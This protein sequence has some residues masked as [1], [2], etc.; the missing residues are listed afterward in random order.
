MTRST[1]VLALLSI[2]LAAPASGATGPDPAALEKLRAMGLPFT[3]GAFSEATLSGNLPA[4]QAYLDAGM[5]PNTF[6]ENGEFIATYSERMGS[7]T[8]PDVLQMLTKAGLDWKKV[9]PTKTTMAAIMGR[10]LSQEEEVLDIAAIGLGG[11]REQAL[12]TDMANGADP[13]SLTTLYEKLHDSDKLAP[14]QLPQLRILEKVS[15]RVAKEAPPTT[16]ATFE[17]RGVR[18][19]MTREEVLAA[20]KSAGMNAT[21]RKVY[22]HPGEVAIEMRDPTANRLMSSNVAA[23]AA[24]ADAAQG[25]TG[26]LGKDEPSGLKMM[27]LLSAASSRVFEFTVRNAANDKTENAR[28]GQLYDIAVQKWGKPNDRSVD[29]TPDR[30][31]T[32]WGR[33][34]GIHA[35]YEAAGHGMLPDLDAGD[36][37]SRR[38]WDITVTDAQASGENYQITHPAPPAPKF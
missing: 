20:A 16:Q 9:N 12:K 11:D 14:S 32:R 4:L 8:W 23:A 38:P 19:G 15:N 36:A 18:L 5:S 7:P 6:A 1:V 3:V 33:T 27:V 37:P 30:T 29:D 24:L 35:T 25:G 28:S 17:A 34:D 10:Q 21:V 22:G 2:A 31:V 26:S 13:T